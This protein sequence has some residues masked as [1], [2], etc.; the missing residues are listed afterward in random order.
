[1]ERVI[2]KKNPL[3]EVI[4]QY[5]FPKIL[6]LNSGDPVE[7][8]EAIR[9]DYPNYQLTLENQQEISFSIGQDSVPIPSLIQRQPVRNHNFI[10]QD[11]KYKINLTSGFISISTIGYTRWEELLSR[12]SNPIKE[13]E[14]IYTPSFYERIGLRYVD[15]FS[16]K[17]LK[18]EEK[19]WKEL[20][21]QPWLG[22]FS[23][24]DE[25][26]MINM[27]LDVEYYLDLDDNTSRAKIH[28]G[29][30]V[31]NNS[32]EKVFVIDSDFIHIKNTVAE[33]ASSVL[34][35]LHVNAKSFIRSAITDTLHFA[36]KPEEVVS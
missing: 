27:G 19:P 29:V 24:I 4:V 26:K 12:F 5:K 7:F 28:T 30:G 1:M 6:A 23:S 31:L 25:S 20:I 34:E 18:L 8:Q 13:F 33:N 22:A 9:R 17:N 35:Y 16:R 3:I 10:S 11:G 32:P 36:M 15:A 14:R 2:Y 21:K